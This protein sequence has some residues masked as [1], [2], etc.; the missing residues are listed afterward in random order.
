MIAIWNLLRSKFFWKNIG[1]A[2]LVVALLLL[3]VY[4]SLR[5]L[6]RHGEQIEVPN[7]IGL[8]EEEARMFL[9]QRGIAVEVI[10]SVQVRGYKPG[11]IVEQNPVAHTFVKKGRK[12]YLTLNARNPRVLPLPDLKD[13]SYRQAKAMLESVGFI[14][15]N[16]IY[17]PSEFPGLVQNVQYQGVVVDAGT[18]L[19]DGSKVDL[20]V[21]QT[22]DGGDLQ[23]VPSFVMLTYAEAQRILAEAG[24][25]LG[26]VVCDETILSE[27]DRNEAFVCKQEPKP[28]EWINKG[29][30]IDLWLTKDLE[31][32]NSDNVQ[33]TEE[34]I[35]F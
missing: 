21:G 27:T 6:T 33:Q 15:E 31:K 19:P 12:I 18:R 20:V 32:I 28:D 1:V 4:F 23:R 35:F 26:A 17:A 13:V 5:N 16:V 2:V 29:K 14:V 10:D 34:E 3:G 11:E 22:A 9:E 25:V 8:Y 24:F 7:L 30:R